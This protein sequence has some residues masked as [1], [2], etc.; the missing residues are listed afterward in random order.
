MTVRRARAL[1]TSALVCTSLITAT[2]SSMSS[3]SRSERAR[4]TGVVQ[5]SQNPRIRRLQ[6]PRPKHYHHAT[7]AMA[8]TFY[9]VR[10]SW[11]SRLTLNNKGP[12]AK[13]PKI[14][15]FSTQGEPFLIPGVEVPGNGFLD[16]D[17]NAVAAKAG[18][19]FDHGSIRMTYYGDMLEMGAQIVISD[20]ERGL[21]FDEQ[22]SYAPTGGSP[23]LEAVW[24]LP[25]DR[26]SLSIAL[27]NQGGEPIV[28]RGEL[29]GLRRSNGRE[30]PGRL[31]E[32]RLRP[33]EMRVIRL[34]AASRGKMES[35]AGE[36][37]WST[38]DRPARCW[39]AASSRT[40]ARDIHRCSSSRTPPPRGRRRFTGAV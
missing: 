9:D 25:N 8:A 19:V 14:T 17:L 39:L 38:T 15:L 21:Q 26:A 30:G 11:T 31:S 10:G 7:Y 16:L 13:R 5:A 28:V 40:D 27:T 34:P 18:R 29:S 35:L 22:L 20:R 1:L 6:P 12:A 37:H 32:V 24:W 36:F 23:R 2:E 4:L 3:I 33:N